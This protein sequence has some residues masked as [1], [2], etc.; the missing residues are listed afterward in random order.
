MHSASRRAKPQNEESYRETVSDTGA[1]GR[2]IRELRNS[3]GIG[4]RE[5][6]RQI[7]VSP[8]LISHI[9]LGKGPPSV[10]T[11]YSL[12]AALGVHLSEIFNHCKMPDD[13]F[14]LRVING[15]RKRNS[16]PA[17]TSEAKPQGLGPVLRGSDRPGIQLEHGFRWERLT[18]GPDPEVEFLETIIAV[19]GGK[20]DSEMKTHNGAEYGIV[21]RGKLGIKIAFESFI[22]QPQDS[23][24]F[25][26]T[27][28]HCMWNAGDE[29]VH[30]IWFVRGRGRLD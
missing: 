2:R 25:E 1:L 18:P 5:L 12:V 4:V 28:P 17:I 29:P 10:K 30:A 7:N 22:L 24:R 11:L 20:P 19:G 8:S 3:K 26:S 15:S 9:E 27:L 14:S 16:S 21:L 13:E 23:I 6:A